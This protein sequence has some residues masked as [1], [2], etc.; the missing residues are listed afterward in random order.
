M[1]KRSLEDSEAV[2]VS[3]EARREAKRLKKGGKIKSGETSARAQPDLVATTD[4][5]P[6]S[7]EERR[8]SKKAKKEAAKADLAESAA[9]STAAASEDTEADAKAA[10][11]AARK[12]AKV[13]QASEATSTSNG[14]SS[15]ASNGLAYNQDPALSALPQ[16]EID[17]FVAEK[18][19][20]I[21]DP[22]K[23]L[24]RPITNFKYLPVDEAQRAPFAKFESPTPIQAACWPYLLAGRDVVGVAET[25]SGKT[26]AFGVPCIRFIASLP[27]SQRNGIK[28]CIVSPTR[29]LAMQIYEQLVKQGESAGVKVTCVYG[30]TVKDEQRKTLKGTHVIVA[31]PGRLNDFVQEGSIDLSGARYVVLDEADRMLDKGFEDEVRKIISATAPS[32]RQTLMFTATWP[33]SVRELADTFMSEPV[34]VTIGDNASGE[35]RANTRIVQEV[36]VMTQFDKQ[37]R[38]LELLKQ[39]QSGKNKNDRILVFCLYKKEATRVEET[40]RRRGFNVAG[41]HGDLNQQKRTESLAAF[42]AGSVP[43]LVATDVAARGLDIPAVKHV[44]NVTFPLTVEDYVHR[45]GRTGRAG[46]DGHAY[47]MFTDAEKGLAG[48]LINVLKSANQSV[49]EELMKFGTTVKK[50]GHDAYGAFYKDT[51]D[52]K[53]ATKIT[54]D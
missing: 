26:L 20:A 18:Q 41:I 12:A 46:Q 32:G 43:V 16:A 25:G 47:T 51:G 33:P 54:F 21:E 31:T 50:K 36:E 38:L 6:L 5:G 4:S 15:E 29:E 37:N 19:L 42:K 1:S 3:K 35:L 48:A 9:T 40:I 8:A 13:E 45:I 39:Y 23:Q 24:Y 14:H 17:T 27:K 7:K 34:K 30:G 49:P 22:K 11:K 2:D 53:K 28:A 10:R 52:M 44:I